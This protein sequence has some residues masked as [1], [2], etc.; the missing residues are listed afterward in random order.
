MTS[1]NTFDAPSTVAPKPFTGASLADGRLSVV[2][3]AKS[4]VTL[5]LP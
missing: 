2:M 1:H 3:P 5:E 4:V